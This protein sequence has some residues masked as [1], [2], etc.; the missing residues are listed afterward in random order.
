MQDIPHLMGKISWFCSWR[1]QLHPRG[2][3]CQVSRHKNTPG[4][5]SPAQGCA[6][7]QSRARD[8]SNPS[9]QPQDVLRDSNTQ[10]PQGSNHCWLHSATTPARGQQRIWVLQPQ[11]LLQSPGKSRA[12]APLLSLNCHTLVSFPG[13]QTFLHRTEREAEVT[14]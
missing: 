11:E 3:R 8:R 4:V 5:A 6:L 12:A 9:I 14:K 1:A 2:E 7:S 13:K 10:G